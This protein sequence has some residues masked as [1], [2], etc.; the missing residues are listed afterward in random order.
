ML[1]GEIAQ[2]NGRTQT[3][4]HSTGSTSAFPSANNTLLHGWNRGNRLGIDVVPL[5]LAIDCAAVA[6]AVLTVRLPVLSAVLLLACVLIIN[7]GGGHYRPRVAPSLLDELPSLAARAL[8]AGALVAAVRLVTDIGVRDAPVIAALVFI[9]FAALGRLIGYSVIRRNRRIGRLSQPTL[10]VGCGQVGNQLAEAL[11][12]HPEY[13]LTPVGYVDDDPLIPVE[14][15]QV[16]LLG[17]TEELTNL[18][19]DYR[20][21]NVIFAFTTSRESVLVDLVRLCDRMACDI[22]FVPRL[23]ELH[24]SG[25]DTELIWGLPM[26][27]L[28][29]ASYRSLSWHAKRVFDFVASLL[30]LLVL[31]PVMLI[32]ALAV[33]LESGRDVI[34]KQERVGLDGRRFKVL[35]FRSLKPTD[36]LES[37]HKWNIGEDARLG[38]VGKMLRR[39]SLDE[40][41]QLWNVVRG[42]MSLVGPRPERPV[43][44]DQFM[45]QF[46]RYMARHRVP[47]G[48]TGWAQVNGLRG[49]TDIA[50]RASFDNYYIENWSLWTDIKILIRTAGQVLGGRG[51]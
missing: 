8:V 30:G 2:R 37:A 33:R 12:E 40:L 41:P 44:V 39:L 3:R 7:A 29:R 49:D 11:K 5:V 35:K 50:D 15:R 22:F 25:R 23:Y 19:V 46:P 51:R 38:P 42:D 1:V 32:C 26:T 4:S 10:I 14:D 16:P 34:F 9:P 24:G 20:I 36:D 45:Q 27:R 28:R 48:L 21:H 31:S 6:S 13:G 47:A 18:L 17:S 43:F